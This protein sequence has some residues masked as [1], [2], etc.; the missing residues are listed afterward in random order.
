MILTQQ[1]NTEISNKKEKKMK[2]NEKKS[3]ILQRRLIVIFSAIIVCF[4]LMPLHYGFAETKMA[5]AQKVMENVRQMAKVYEEGEHLVV[6]F[7]EYLFPYDI[8]QRLKFVSIIADADCVIKG[9]AR[10]IFFLNP[11]EKQ[12]AQAD[13]LNGVRLKE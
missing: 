4:F 9:K 3:V 7:H 5:S 6:E 1:R 10:T 13:R 12:F 11:G 8:N 2:K